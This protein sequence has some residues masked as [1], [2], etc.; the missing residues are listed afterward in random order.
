MNVRRSVT[1]AQDI[2]REH[3]MFKKTIVI[4]LVSLCPTVAKA[5]ELVR[6]RRGRDARD[7]G[8][9]GCEAIGLLGKA[10]TGCSFAGCVG[11]S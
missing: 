3:N 5:D 9:L 7:T 2:R 11:D 10:G 6:D 8:V 1:K 4:L